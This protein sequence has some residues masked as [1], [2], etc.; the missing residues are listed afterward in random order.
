M[1]G[2]IAARQRK[3]RWLNPGALI[4]AAK[5]ANVYRV[6]REARRCPDPQARC[7]S[8]WS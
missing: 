2:F 8:S 3:F 5:S 6:K 1:R 7:S 4:A